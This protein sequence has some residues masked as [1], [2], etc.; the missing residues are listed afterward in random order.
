MSGK[1]ES[2]R[3]VLSEWNRLVNTADKDGV[4]ALYTADAVLLP[5]FSG[6][7]RA[8]SDSIGDYFDGLSG[9]DAIHV[10]IHE[11]TL[12][13]QSIEGSVHCLSGKYLW[14]WSKDGQ[15][16]RIEARFTYLIDT[17]RETPILHHHSSVVPEAS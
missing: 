1:Y 2:P 13:S 12:V 11:D 10:L 17:A 4:L 15:Q 7:I 16:S 9:Y 8:S 6:T 3:E 5:T 14:E